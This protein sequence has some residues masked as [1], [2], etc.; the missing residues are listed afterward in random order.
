MISMS[1]KQEV[2]LRYFREGQSKKGIAR[3]LCLAP[4]TVRKYIREH[5]AH[6]QALSEAEGSVVEQLVERLTEAPKYDSSGR[7]KKRLT[8]EVCQKIDAHLEQNR[9]KRSS[10]RHKQ[11]LKKIDIH[12]CLLKAGHQI[13]YTAVCNYIRRAEHRR[14]EAYIRQVYEPGHTCE[15]DWGEVKLF[16]G[17][18]LRTFQLAVFTSAM[19]NYRWARLFDRQ[20]RASFQQ[21]HAEF[22]WHLQGVY[23]EMVYDNTRVVIRRFVG[24]QE[25]E[26]T[27]GLLRLSMY[28]QFSFRFCNVMRGNEKEHV[29]RSVEYIRRKAFGLRDEFDSREQANAYLLDSCLDFQN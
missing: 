10:G 4:K 12:E 28:Y 9:V 8:N 23:Y 25:K 18:E 21:A 6:R 17:G 19:S 3:D 16:I 14:Q 15:F 11:V 22:F 24:R 29:E 7:I 1:Q 26:P 13:G 27:E 20:D 5:A 2:I